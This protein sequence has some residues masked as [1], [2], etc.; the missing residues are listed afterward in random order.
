VSLLR[1]AGF[2][3]VRLLDFTTEAPLSPSSRRAL[4][5]ATK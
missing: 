4:V 3:L 1:R 2:G 5:I